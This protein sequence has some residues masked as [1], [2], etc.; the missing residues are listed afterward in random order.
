MIL[1]NKKVLIGMSGGVDSSVAAY[2]LKKQGYDVTGA[3]LIMWN[4]TDDTSVMDAKEVAQKIGIPHITINC[5]NEFRE[6]VIEYFIDEYKNGRTPN[7]CIECN[8]FIKFGFML[9]YAMDNGYDYI[10]TGHYAKIEYDKSSNCHYIKKADFDSKDQTYVLYGL[11]KDNLPKILMPLWEYSKDQIREI[12]KNEIGMYI[13]NKPDSMEICFVPDDDYKK[14]IQTYSNYIPCTGNFVDKSGKVLGTH[15]GII[16]FTI[17]QRKGLGQTFGK[18][19]FVTGID[20]IS[21]DVVLGEKGD[22]YSSG[23]IAENVNFFV[24]FDDVLF[25]QC[26][27]RYSSKHAPCKVTKLDKTTVKVEF[28][29]NQRAVTPGQS[30]VFYDNDRI[31]GG[32]IIKSTF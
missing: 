27:T 2:L 31:L 8:K 29:Q 23:L 28:E 22:E 14:F 11:K 25:T 5:E 1:L 9:D 26:K 13:A 21:N 6:H 15:D 30:V 4:N 18:P 3:T 20:P 24:C 19:M 16:N 32:G 17:G 7:P 12:A 10:A